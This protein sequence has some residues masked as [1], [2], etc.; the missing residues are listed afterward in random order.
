MR[1]GTVA[2]SAPGDAVDLDRLHALYFA[3]D[4]AA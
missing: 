3:H 4:D 1:S 2:L